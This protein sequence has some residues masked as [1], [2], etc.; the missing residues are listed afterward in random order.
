MPDF[1]VCLILYLLWLEGVFCLILNIFSLSVDLHTL[2]TF[3]SWV[4]GYA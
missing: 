4:L 1:A 2:E 3:L